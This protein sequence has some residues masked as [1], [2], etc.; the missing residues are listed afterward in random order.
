MN[1]NTSHKGTGCG[2][3]GGGATTTT[4]ACS[5][6]GGGCASCQ[7]QGIVRPRF[8]AGQLL[9]EDD[10]QLLADYSIQKSRLHNRYLFG[11][12][13]VCGLEVT[14]DPC[15]NGQVIVHPG[16]A[17]DCCGN[18]LTL[19]CA[20]SLNI[21]KMIRDLLR[22]QLG[23]F[24]CGDPCPDLPASDASSK[25]GTDAAPL[26]DSPGGVIVLPNPEQPGTVPA[27]V[28]RYCLY[29]R[30]CEQPTDPVMPYSTGDD[31]GRQGCE[32]T[33]VREGIKFEVRC[34]PQHG[35]ANPLIARLCACLGDMVTLQRIATL[36]HQLESR[37][38]NLTL[39]FS[40]SSDA[41]FNAGLASL[42]EKVP[43]LDITGLEKGTQSTDRQ[44]GSS[45][46]G[47]AVNP[48]SFASLNLSPELT[49]NLSIVA[50]VVNRYY[51]LPVAEQAA[52]RSKIQGLDEAILRQGLEKIEVARAVFINDSRTS[53][54][55]IHDWLLRRLDNTPYLTDCTLR[56]RV[57][58]MMIPV[59]SPQSR[60]QEPVRSFVSTSNQLVAAFFDYVRDCLCRAL[61]PACEPC[62]DS[63][64]LLACFDV[65]EC[66]VVKVCNLERT[67]VLSPAAVRYWMPPLQLLGNL[68][69][70]LCCDPFDS[71]FTNDREG[72]KSF[73]INKLLETEVKKILTDS[74][75]SFNPDANWGTTMVNSISSLFR[76]AAS[77]VSG[78]ASE[79]SVEA[80]QTDASVTA[81]DEANAVDAAAQAGTDGAESEVEGVGEGPEAPEGETKTP[82]K[83]RSVR[84]PQVDS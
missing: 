78:L 55:E 45:G 72:R 58:A 1:A 12:G 28:N 48:G 35:A 71:L 63:G 60:S 39:I 18:D 83:K 20:Q 80:A 30:Y 31:C 40:Q 54:A 66:K 19:D 62:E 73:N 81:S 15:G 64:V 7:G 44:T 57:K 75:C 68:V 29:I 82:P 46:M 79:A 74:L 33:R 8:F 6:G 70:T 50:G 21:N 27:R 2:C 77:K 49:E 16:Y 84:K 59:L 4:A 14:C 5:C 61:N 76:S 23:G 52:L 26:R 67:F 17:L 41:S 34:Q 10:L 25:A 38:T 11:A 13:V 69:E 47:D 42:K 51:M 9:T 65:Q 56:P 43:A 22:N 32:A 37:N 3:G 53:F 24:D 36:A